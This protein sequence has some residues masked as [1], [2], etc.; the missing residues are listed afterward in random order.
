MSPSIWNLRFP[1]LPH[2]IAW[3]ARVVS[4]VRAGTEDARAGAKPRLTYRDLRRRSRDPVPEGQS[5][6]G[7]ARP[8]SPATRQAAARSRIMRSTHSSPSRAMDR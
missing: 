2:N 6:R 7:L 8:R 3:L 1:A 5:R 4:P